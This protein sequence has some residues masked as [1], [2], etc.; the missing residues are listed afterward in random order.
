MD[1]RIKV[2]NGD[3]TEPNLGLSI[4]DYN[5]VKNDVD[6]IINSG[7]IVKHYGLKQQFEDINVVGTQ[8][9]VDLCKKEKITTCFYYECFWI[10]RKRK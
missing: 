3:I 6:V 9:V 7:A 2:L 5:T 1:V 10:W 4:E 8:N